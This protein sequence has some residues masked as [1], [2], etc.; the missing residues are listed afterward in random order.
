[1]EII[2]TVLGSIVTFVVGLLV[3][4]LAIFVAAQLVV[5]KGD[6]RT[7]VWTAVFGALGWLVA[8]LVVGWIPFHIGS[9]LGTLLGL[10]VYLT[11][12]AVQYDTDWVEAAA[13][14]FVAWVSVLVARFFLA[15]LLGD[16]GVVGVPFV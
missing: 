7:A 13:I 11:V 2:A 15:P 6:F 5:G 3:G 10:A 12:I 9:I 8:T 4:G 16:W 14:A 1:M